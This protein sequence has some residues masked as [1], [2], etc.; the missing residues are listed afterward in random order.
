MDVTNEIVDEEEYAWQTFV[1]TLAPSVQE[2]IRDMVKERQ[3]SLTRMA[4]TAGW[5]AYKAAACL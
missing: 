3:P 4:F 5:E 2:N 1:Q